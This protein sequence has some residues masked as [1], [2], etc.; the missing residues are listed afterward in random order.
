MKCKVRMTHTVEMVVEGESEDDIQEWLNSTTPD[1]AKGLAN[2]PVYEYWEEEIV[3]N[4]SEDEYVDYVICNDEELHKENEKVMICMY[5]EHRDNDVHEE[6]C[7]G[8]EDCL[9]T[10]M[11]NPDVE[12]ES[13]FEPRKDG[14]CKL[15]TWDELY[16]RADGA[17]CGSHEL[18]AKDKARHLLWLIINNKTGINIEKCEIPEEAIEQFL[19]GQTGKYMFDENGNFVGVRKC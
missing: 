6:P 1:E 19:S 9:V 8:C 5:C 11:E 16:E 10:H 13:R 7:I 14:T 15:Y 17:A 3:C 4:A 18:R 2:S 12:F